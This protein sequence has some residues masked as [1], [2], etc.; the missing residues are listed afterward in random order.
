MGALDDIRV[1]DLSRVLAGPYCGQLLADNGAAVIKVEAPG[2]DMNRAFPHVLGPGQ[3]TNFTGV[4]R[5]KRDLSLN[6]KSP[7]AQAIVH[8]LVAK[9]DVVIQSF[10]PDTA[11]KLGV[12]YE[13][14]SALNPD[15]IYAS[16]SGY[17]AKGELANKPGYDLMVSAFGGVM[18]LTGE[19]DRP[20]VRVGVTL[21]DLS[22]GMLAYSGI[23][24]ALHARAT[25]KAR[26]QRVDVSLLESAVSLL[27]FHAVGYLATGV[28]DRREGSGYSTLAPYGSYRCADGEI[29][30]GAPTQPGWEKLCAALGD[31]SLLNDPR[32]A[33]NET[34]CAHQEPLREAIERALVQRP[35]Q[36][37]LQV[38]EAAGLPCAP[39][40][41]VDQ[42]MT[43][44]Q[45]LANDMVLE[46]RRADGSSVSL[47]G[48]PFKLSTTPA[49]AGDAPPEPG[50]HNAEI[51]AEL[52]G[53]SDTEIAG[54][55]RD[56]VI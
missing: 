38:I 8:Q 44:P 31:H 33:S 47:L 12:D 17:G 18:S 22:T 37:W 34:R 29:M 15:L 30:L 26:G 49:Q 46:S 7:R 32:F 41:S 1:L 56:G 42:V 35:M 24:T 23:L 13:T 5:G 53:M 40:H 27:G 10:L 20:P 14:L 43:H 52:L 54:L 45:V 11:R 9:T 55:A 48:M 50:Q 4:N 25:G 2:G 3:S 16:I 21:I 28:V 6:L 39:I 36:H 51:L 19:P